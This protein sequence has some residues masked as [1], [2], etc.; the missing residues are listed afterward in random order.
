LSEPEA[1][2]HHDHGE[3]RP[4]DL[5]VDRAL[6]AADRDA[7]DHRPV[8][9][10]V[11]ELVA[12]SETPLNVAL[13]GAW[14]SGKS[15]FAHLIEDSL[16]RYPGVKLVTYNAW[17]F[18]GESLQRSFISGVATV[19]GMIEE[20]SKDYIQFHSGLYEHSRSARLNLTRDAFGKLGVIVGVVAGA[21]L[22]F[23]AAVVAMIAYVAGEDVLKQVVAAIP[24]LLPATAVTAL[25]VTGVQQLVAGARVD[26][27]TSAPTQ[28]QFR[29]KFRTLVERARTDKHHKRL[30]FFI[31]EL[32]RCPEDQIVKVLAAIRHFFDQPDCVFV[33]AADRE[34]IE[35][36]LQEK[37]HQAIPL[38]TSNPYYSSASEYIDKIFQHQLAL[39]PLRG[40][41]LT[42]FARDLVEAKSTGLWRELGAVDEGRLRQQLVYVLVPSHVRSPRRVKVLLNNFATD[43]R[44]AQARGIDALGSARSIAKL[45]AIR[46]EFPLFAADLVTEPRL[47]SMLLNPPAA[48]GRLKELLDRHKLPSKEEPSPKNLTATDPVLV[49]ETVEKQEQLDDLKLLQRT[50][51]RRYLVRTNEIPDASRDLLYLEPAGAA[52]GLADQAFG[53]LL[54]SVAVEDP[55][56]AVEM[57]KAQPPEEVLKAIRVL[58]DMVSQEFGTERTNAVSAMLGL[59]EQLA[60][61]VTLYGDE[62]LGALKVQLDDPG[63]DASQ[64]SSALAVAVKVEG[65][66]RTLSTA[67]L[68]NP[69]L[70]EDAVQTSAVAAIADRLES[71]QRSL[72]WEKV[73]EFY[74]T[75]PEIL[76]EPLRR[77]DRDTAK[78]LLE[79]TGFP[80][81]RR[82]RWNDLPADDAEE[83]I[84]DLLE[85]ASEREG[86]SE[87]IRGALLYQMA[88]EGGNGYAGLLRHEADLAGFT[89]RPGFRAMVAMVAIRVGPPTD[90]KVWLAHLDPSA[91]PW[92]GQG[93]A[94]A[95]TAVE[96]LKK[97][98]AASSSVPGVVVA[99]MEKLARLTRPV[100][101]QAFAEKVT[102]AAT[103]AVGT[104]T[105]WST[106]AAASAQES[107]HRALL[108]LRDAGPKTHAAV[109]RVVGTDLERSYTTPP[110][111]F[112]FRATRE[113]AGSVEAGALASL[114][115]SVHAAV[116][117]AALLE[118]HALAR[119]ALA[120]AARTAGLDALGA[121]YGINGSEMVAFLNTPSRTQLVSGW[122]GLGPD[123]SS[124]GQVA[125]A[126]G[127]GPPTNERQAVAKW[128]ASLSVDERTDLL[129]QLTGLANDAGAWVRAVA[130][131]PV[132]E[133]KIVGSMD[134]RIRAAT[135]G[136]DRAELAGT[137]AAIRPSRPSAQKA[138]AHTVVWLLS[139][140]KKIDDDAAAALFPALG[141]KHRMGP[142]LSEAVTRADARGTH[143]TGRALDDLRRANVTLRKKSVS[144][145]FWTRWR[146]R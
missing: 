7:L 16:E 112:S 121:P 84:D 62:I 83:E 19:L 42:Q 2:P 136:D 40:R 132:D 39:P 12:T 126:L 129:L 48:T 138:I 54:E 10:R 13:F 113:C 78:E 52:V 67:L 103:S 135:R 93:Q 99:V 44:I 122:Y 114:A 18:E 141:D 109:S 4:E 15:S 46:T 117:P 102:P 71:A 41:R 74:P 143:F 107:L 29:Q 68:A 53:Q 33:V 21:V 43:Y 69:R 119:L 30:V 86:E 31:D 17:T 47:P 57:A 106:E 88:N 37:P 75:E 6:Q 28:E 23:L 32:D 118:D 59:A 125:L 98:P 94:A 133:E 144:E 79:Y 56:Q 142:Q 100:D 3:L 61:E 76:D 73:L 72:I 82:T 124:G 35:A 116:A 1:S 24:S 58:A 90:W 55:K 128:T 9:D 45:T 26:V 127:A 66:D 50:L 146:G 89:A 123:F 137:L 38:N 64:L 104:A 120:E 85:I 134:A 105:W 95:Q 130:A 70:M 145:R 25:L 140:G 60:F 97:W 81:A 80:K 131:H 91:K 8:A 14:G 22:V 11:A 96:I 63:F 101:D 77:L 27:D 111:A 51:L 139:Q 65:K 108:S 36:A 20:G 92:P 5:I 115:T 87:G 110:T 34:V 49:E